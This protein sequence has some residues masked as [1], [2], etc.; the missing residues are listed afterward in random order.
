[1]IKNT[2]WGLGAIAI[3]MAILLGTADATEVSSTNI[4][5]IERFALLQAFHEEAILDHNTQLIWE[6]SPHPMEVTWTT[7]ATRCAL[8][9]VGGN[10]GW[11]LPSFI[12][13]MTLVEPHPRQT[14]ANPTLPSGHPFQGVKATAYWTND[15]PSNEPAQAYTVDFLRA[16]VAPHRKNQTHPLWCVRGGVTDPSKPAPLIQRPDLL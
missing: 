11:R 9:I 7:A 6:R 14:S 16:D 2:G 8:K 12:E 13:L 5:S 3:G 1:V 10:R 4:I 15:T